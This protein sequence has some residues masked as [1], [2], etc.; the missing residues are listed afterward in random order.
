MLLERRETLVNFTA[1]C[2]DNQ[3]PPD[4]PAAA[5][6]GKLTSRHGL[7]ARQVQPTNT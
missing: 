2:F 6:E 1:E 4:Y 5:N 7:L 3:I